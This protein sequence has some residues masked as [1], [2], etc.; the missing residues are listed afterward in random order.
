M[1]KQYRRVNMTHA[2]AASPGAKDALR[3]SMCPGICNRGMWQAKQTAPQDRGI[4]SRPADPDKK[5][6]ARFIPNK[7]EVQQLTSP[8]Q[9]FKRSLGRKFCNI[10]GA[11]AH[12]VK[13]FF[14]N[15][16]TKGGNSTLSS[17]RSPRGRISGRSA[18]VAPLRGRMPMTSSSF[19]RACSAS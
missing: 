9:Q 13:R 16:S 4:A 11:L 6:H 10:S 15:D 19:K 3:S 12:W 7:K 17:T 18:A 14:A 5:V 2:T 1:H 8:Q